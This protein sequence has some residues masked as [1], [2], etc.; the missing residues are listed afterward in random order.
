MT[1]DDDTDSEGRLGFFIINNSW[2]WSFH[3]SKIIWICKKREAH[4][5]RF[6]W[7]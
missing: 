2:Q 7:I 6:G 5:E 4:S 1:N 3:S